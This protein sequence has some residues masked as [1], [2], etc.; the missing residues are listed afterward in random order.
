MVVDAVALVGQQRGI[1]VAL[2]GFV[3]SDGERQGALD[4]RGWKFSGEVVGGAQHCGILEVD[5]DRITP[6]DLSGPL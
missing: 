2:I 3:V 4:A 1:P 5:G 6:Q